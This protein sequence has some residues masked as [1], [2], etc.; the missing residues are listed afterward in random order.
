MK[1]LYIF[2]VGTL[3]AFNSF[4]QNT[5]SGNLTLLKGQTIRL[6]GFNGLGIYNIDSTQINEQG[7]F[8]LQFSNTDLG[9]GYI[10]AAD[11]KPYFVVLAKEQIQINGESLT[12]TETVITIKGNE[13]KLFITYAKE[14]VK[15]EQALS[16]WEYLQKIYQ[17][18]AIFSGQII[19]QQS[20]ATNFPHSTP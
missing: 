3:V 13:N 4:A 6:V 19:T 17:A 18:D 14:H 8:S 16:A 1:L 12:A 7:D 5:L 20:I 2:L 11:N 10:A 15:R 9:M